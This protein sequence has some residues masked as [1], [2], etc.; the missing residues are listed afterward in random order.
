MSISRRTFSGN[1]LA[2][3][4]ASALLNPGAAR[5]SSG[6]VSSEEAP[7]DAYA[8]WNGFF[9]SV[10]RGEPGYHAG[11]RAGSTGLA[12]PKV[13]TQ[14]LHYKE[15]AKKLRY[16][17]VITPD[18]LM[19]HEGDVALSIELSQFMPADRTNPSNQQHQWRIDATQ[20]HAYMNLLAP[21]AWTAIASIKPTLG[22]KMPSLETLGFKSDQA[23]SATKNILLTQ[24]TGKLAVNVSLPPNDSQFLKVLKIMISGARMAAPLLVLPA[25]SVPAMSAFSEA[26]GYWED[27]TRF[28]M[29]GNL[30]TA[31]ATKQAF[32]DPERSDTYLGLLNGDYV[33]VGKQDT[34]ALS[35]AMDDLQVSGGW[36]VHKEPS[37]KEANQLPETQAMSILPG[38]AYTTMKLAL[39]PV[40][41]SCPKNTS[42]SSSDSS[43]SAA[44][45]KPE[46]KKP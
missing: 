3:A 13:E 2:L 32:K 34:Q 12:D 43:G 24:G 17:N 40:D 35:D 31:V 4:F 23:M 29:N 41:A 11:A 1:A 18:E 20:T 10:N 45:K 8:F 15:D 33:M 44:S 28:V 14:Y 6:E 26:F 42:D 46:K 39:K 22:N 25:V 9:D 27:R 5:A 30:T 38:V 37:S 7:H 21:L 19:D 16:A 36:L